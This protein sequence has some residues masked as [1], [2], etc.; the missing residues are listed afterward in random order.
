MQIFLFF[1]LLAFSKQETTITDNN[2]LASIPNSE[3][4]L[5]LKLK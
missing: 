4:N 1:I 3:T 2:N 5:T